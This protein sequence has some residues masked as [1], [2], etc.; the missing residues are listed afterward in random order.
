M[1]ASPC[2]LTYRRCALNFASHPRQLSAASPVS[3]QHKSR[4]QWQS[5][6]P[7]V[8]NSKKAR[9]PVP[10]AKLLAFLCSCIQNF[11]LQCR[12]NRRQG[13]AFGGGLSRFLRGSQTVVRTTSKRVRAKDFDDSLLAIRIAKRAC[14]D[15]VKFQFCSQECGVCKG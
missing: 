10:N 8:A 3:R 14:R 12:G 13:T 7:K 5:E 1:F 6:Q 11:G 15:V 9:L 4:S 2:C